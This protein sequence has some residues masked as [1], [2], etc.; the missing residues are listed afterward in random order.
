MAGFFLEF[1]LRAHISTSG[2]IGHNVSDKGLIHWLYSF[3]V[4]CSFMPV[5][6]TRAQAGGDGSNCQL[7]ETWGL[8]APRMDGTASGAV[9]LRRCAFRGSDHLGSEIAAARH[10]LS[11]ER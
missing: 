8:R 4:V 10:H 5:E 2:D 11:L 3:L 1:C 9:C 6:H 7:D